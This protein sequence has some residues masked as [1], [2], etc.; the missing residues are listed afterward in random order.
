MNTYRA[1]NIGYSYQGRQEGG[2]GGLEPKGPG[3]GSGTQH[4][5]VKFGS[6]HLE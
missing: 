1:Y 4:S 2:A 6:V 3:P 5:N